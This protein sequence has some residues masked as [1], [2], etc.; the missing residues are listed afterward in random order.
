MSGTPRDLA[1]KPELRRPRRRWASW[2]VLIALL[3]VIGFPLAF[4]P[5]PGTNDAIILADLEWPVLLGITGGAI[6]AY[7][8]YRADVGAYVRAGLGVLLVVSAASLVVGLL[9]FGNLS[10]DRFAPLLFFPPVFGLLGLV[11]IVVAV[12]AG[13]VRHRWWLLRGG[14]TGLAFGLLFAV[15]LFTRGARAW[16]LAPYGF[17]L[18]LLLAVLGVGV[19]VLGTSPNTRRDAHPG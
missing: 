8:V 3:A 1:R 15:L 18:L 12:A 19:V 11:G 17:D 13:S 6:A 14:R 4:F 5:H 7:F 10:N 16:L 9:V 2:F